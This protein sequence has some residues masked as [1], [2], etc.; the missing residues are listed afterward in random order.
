MSSDALSEGSAAQ[1][2]PVSETSAM[3]DESN[4]N[5]E[6]QSEDAGQPGSNMES[7]ENTG[8]LPDGGN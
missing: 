2:N 3:P 5:N 7:D 1:D 4:Q 6:Q 8:D